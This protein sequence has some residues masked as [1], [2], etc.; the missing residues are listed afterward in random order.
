MF[1]IKLHGVNKDTEFRFNVH[2]IK[3]IQ[4]WADGKTWI[5]FGDDSLQVRETADQIEGLVRECLDGE[6][7]AFSRMTGKPDSGE[8]GPPQHS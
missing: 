8:G 3:F 5:H 7:D 6:I 1:F 4:V 2:A